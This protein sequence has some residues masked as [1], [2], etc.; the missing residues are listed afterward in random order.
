MKIT[1]CFNIIKRL[2]LIVGFPK[3]LYYDSQINN[4]NLEDQTKIS[5]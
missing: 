4:P 1:T 5:W 3:L 2:T